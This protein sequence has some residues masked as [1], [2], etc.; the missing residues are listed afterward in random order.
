[1][2]AYVL[3]G[4][5]IEPFRNV[6]AYFDFIYLFIYLFHMPLFCFLSGLVAQYRVKKLIFQTGWI[7]VTVS[8]FYYFFRVLVLE[9]TFY[10]SGVIKSIINPWWHLWYLEAIIIW[11]ITLRIAKKLN[12]FLIVLLSIGISLVSGY[13]ELPLGLSRILV[14]Y[15][16]YIVA[17]L[18]KTEIFKYLNFIKTEEKRRKYFEIVVFILIGAMIWL[19]RNRINV[20]SFWNYQSFSQGNYTMSD[21]VF[22]IICAMVMI[23]V[24]VSMC[25]GIN[26]NYIVCLGKRTLPI[27]IFHASIV[28]VFNV[29]GVPEYLI[30]LGAR[31]SGI[32][33]YVLL[34][35]S[36]CI[37]I[38]SNEVVNKLIDF[39]GTIWLK[40]VTNCK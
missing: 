6:N 1:M 27:Y 7:Y 37:L 40:R 25:V 36:G 31:G 39:W 19:F 38:F 10:K 15:L 12:R 28:H 3:V 2:S 22:F 23:C 33:I 34:C 24:T 13:I 17:F 14:F 30:N 8:C 21:R 9:E 35:I 18:Y 16:F 26:E 11:G 5:F 20:E 32:I 29:L 4:H